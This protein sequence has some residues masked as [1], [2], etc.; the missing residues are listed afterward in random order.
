VTFDDGIQLD[1]VL[2]YGQ[3]AGINGNGKIRAAAFMIRRIDK[4]VKISIEVGTHLRDQIP[5]R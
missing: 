5:A 1:A 4:A 2:G 3:V